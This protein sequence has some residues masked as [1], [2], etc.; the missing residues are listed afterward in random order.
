MG[1]GADV[2]TPRETG[3][4]SPKELATRIVSLRGDLGDLI[5]EL[6]RRRHEA[7]D[8]RLQMRKHPV[9]VAVV[10]VTVATLIGVGIAAIVR[11]RRDRERPVEK[12]RRARRALQRLMDDPEHMAREATVGEKILA[13]AG[14]AAASILVRRAMNQVVPA[15]PPPDS[16]R[17]RADAHGGR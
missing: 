15:R 9:A 12:A 5:S 7:F 10:G 1:Q 4:A 13:A 17:D 2:V 8:L 16:R 6:D 3:D 11:D 14:T